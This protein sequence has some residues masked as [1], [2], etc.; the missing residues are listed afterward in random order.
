MLQQ[1][2][3]AFRESLPK[4]QKKSLVTPDAT[5]LRLFMGTDKARK[6]RGAYTRQY[7]LDLL[8]RYIGLEG[9]EGFERVY[10]LYYQILEI[11]RSFKDIFHDHLG[12]QGQI[13][14]FI[15]RYRQNIEQLLPS[16]LQT[17]LPQYL[18]TAPPKLSLAGQRPLGQW[19]VQDI[20][21][22]A[23]VLAEPLEWMHAVI[24]QDKAAHEI[25][26]RHPPKQ[27]PWQRIG[28][29]SSLGLVALLVG[30]W[31]W[32]SQQLPTLTQA[33]FDPIKLQVLAID[34]AKAG[35]ATVQIRYDVSHL[36]ND[37]TIARYGLSLQANSPTNQRSISKAI[38]TVL[39]S[40]ESVG[41]HLIDI[42]S[43]NKQLR[44]RL[45]LYLPAKD[46][47]VYAKS[48]QNQMFGGVKWY[49]KG[50]AKAQAARDGKL[51]FPR[52]FIPKAAQRYFSTSY[53]LARPMPIPMANFRLE[54]RVKTQVDSLLNATCI[55]PDISLR[56]RENEYFCFQMLSKGC[57]RWAA[58]PHRTKHG[59]RPWQPLER[60]KLIRPKASLTQWHTMQ[61][62][63]RQGHYTYLFD[64]QPVQAYQA[65]VIEGNIDEIKVNFKG[66][67]LVDYIKI[68]D[69]AGKLVYEEGFGRQ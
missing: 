46:W 7:T 56:T 30:W 13:N 3:E 58:I 69:G 14:H 18:P 10:Q 42:Q 67:G 20:F 17:S 59:D 34:R 40:Y 48:H 31:V 24:Y 43:K 44:K 29:A 27:L 16:S 8:C 52:Y 41:L 45:P 50:I 35:H 2:L 9:F 60:K 36:G 63:S 64:N 65:P 37:A 54:C 26:E 12:H 6:K 11:T 4:A 23:S 19:S 28:V 49:S 15:Q 33:H 21:A 62:V 61:I 22:Q 39:L 53:V 5:W 47:M 32:Q 68:W 57:S 25:A 1:Q 66:M 38:D 51:C 55:G